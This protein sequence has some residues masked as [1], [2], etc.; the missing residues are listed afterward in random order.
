M[1]KHQF[2]KFKTNLGYKPPHHCKLPANS[3]MH[4]WIPRGKDGEFD[5][6]LMYVDPSN[7]NITTA[8]V[9]GWE[10]DE[11]DSGPTIVTKVLDFFHCRFRNKDFLIL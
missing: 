3:S 6:C 10:F 4:E 1:N 9:D 2:H 11:S 8:C 5:S 7:K